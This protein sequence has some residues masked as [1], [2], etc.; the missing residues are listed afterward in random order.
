MVRPI[1]TKLDPYPAIGGFLLLLSACISVGAIAW[2]VVA[3]VP[4]PQSVP[5]STA[6]TPIC[7]K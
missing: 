3:F 2:A 4:I 6:A 7:N 1:K 5:A